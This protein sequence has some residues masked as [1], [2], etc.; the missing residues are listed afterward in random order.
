[1]RF[2][3]FS[4]RSRASL[5][6]LRWGNAQSYKLEVVN[7]VPLRPI[8]IDWLIDWIND[9]SN[10]I[11]IN[12]VWLRGW[13]VWFQQATGLVESTGNGTVTSMTSLQNKHI[14]R[15]KATGSHSRTRTISVDS[16]SS[17]IQRSVAD[18]KAPTDRKRLKSQ[19]ASPFSRQDIF[20]SGSVTS[21]HEYKTSTDMA[22]Y[23]KVNIT[24]WTTTFDCYALKLVKSICKSQNTVTRR[25]CKPSKNT[26]KNLNLQAFGCEG[27]YDQCDCD[28]H[29]IQ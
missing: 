29:S 23:V 14:E 9:N 25:K 22:T 6:H 18:F 11:A 28:G 1:M 8:A 2:Q 7:G 19:L 10:C 20:Y 3:A 13:Y 17:V 21:L 16:K 15:I 26:N 24:S 12:V 4:Y 27:R 5:G